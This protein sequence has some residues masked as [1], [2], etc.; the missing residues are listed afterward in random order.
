M[1]EE[2][3][4]GDVVEWSSHGGKA[5]GEVAPEQRAVHRGR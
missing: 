3:E 5:S 4:Q 1:A 2:F